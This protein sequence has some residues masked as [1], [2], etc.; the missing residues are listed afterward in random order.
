MNKF[1]LE[2][3]NEAKKG[4]LAGDGG[5]FGAVIVKN[6]KIIGKGHNRVILKNDPT[7]HAEI[8][9]IRDAS[10]NINNFKLNGCEIYITA[11]PCPMCFGAIY[12]ARLDKVYY[13]ADEVDA[14]NI[15]FSDKEIY[16][17]IQNKT[18]PKIEFIQINKKEC[19]E[20][21]RLWSDKKD[22]ILY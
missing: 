9:A 2:A 19:L 3:I 14:E 13:G 5:P 17:I 18:K 8:E 6:N 16:D 10:K 12:W 11:K 20:V 21:F 22:K 7:A 1:M 4:V 15:G